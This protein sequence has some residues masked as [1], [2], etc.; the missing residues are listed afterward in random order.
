MDDTVEIIDGPKLIKSMRDIVN[1]NIIAWEN[2]NGCWE[3]ALDAMETIS[4]WFI[5][6][7]VVTQAKINDFDN[8]PPSDKPF[9]W[10]HTGNHVPIGEKYHNWF[11]WVHPKD[12]LHFS[13]SPDFYGRMGE[14][15]FWGD[16]GRVSAS[17]FAMTQKGMGKGD[18]WISLLRDGSHQVIIEA[19][20]SICEAYGAMIGPGRRVTDSHVS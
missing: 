2:L 11:D 13:D 7:A 5:D 12:E 1:L 14:A 10:S 15:L 16:I 17:T 8:A 18:I 4:S 6:R 3:N 9:A 19:Q 20:Y